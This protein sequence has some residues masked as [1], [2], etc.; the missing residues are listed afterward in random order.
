[1]KTKDNLLDKYYRGET[2]LEEEKELKAQ[3]LSEKEISSEKDVFGYFEEEGS[4]PADLEESVFSAI[5][6]KKS[7]GKTL[8]MRVY[9]AISAAAVVL[10]LLT[11]YLNIRQDRITK[12][13]DDF[14]VMEQALFQVSESLQLE[15][16]EDMLVLWVDDNVEIIIN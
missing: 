16:E 13:N 8:R 2:T 14:F 15:E 4:I 5:E 9:S 6:D 11:V 3:I 7:K 12:M 10:I 1:M